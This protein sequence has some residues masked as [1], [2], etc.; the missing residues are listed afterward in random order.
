[1][2]QTGTILALLLGLTLSVL[3]IAS[4]APGAPLYNSSWGGPALQ[5]ELFA[6]LVNP[7]AL[8]RGSASGFGFILPLGD[9]HAPG[10]KDFGE[11]YQLLLNA[12]FGG[13]A[14]EHRDSSFTHL[15][16]GAL[17][18]GP[19]LSL[20]YSWSWEET[21]F[22]DGHYQAGLLLRPGEAI[23]LGVVYR[24]LPQDSL[25]EAGLGVRPL[26]FSD[27]WGTRLTLDGNIRWIPDEEDLDFSTASVTVEV[28]DG[29]RLSAGYDHQEEVFSLGARVNLR[30]SEAGLAATLEDPGDHIP[31]SVSYG[32]LR[33]TRRRTVLEQPRSEVIEYDRTGRVTSHP[34]VHRFSEPHLPLGTI[35]ADL[36]RFRDDPSVGAI[37][38]NGT[39]LQAPLA[40]VSELL[41][42]FN[43]VRLQGKR[44]FFYFDWADPVAYLLAAAVSDQIFFHP[45]AVLDLR[46]FSYSGL[47]LG[48]FL[49]NYGVDVHNYRSHDYKTAGDSLSEPS[50]TEA[51]REGWEVLLE[52]LADMYNEVLAVARE[53]HL[54]DE[55]DRI[56]AAGPYLTAKGALD[57]GLIDAILYPDQLQETIF[58][59]LP[60]AGR[61]RAPDRTRRATLAWGSDR[62]GLVQVI[63]GTG[64]IIPGEAIAGESIGGDSFSRAIR[65]ARENPFV[66]GIILR[67]ETGGGAITA[68]DQIAREVALTRD[69]G[70]PV[71]VSMGGVAASGGYY[72]SAP[73]SH[74]V[75]N[76]ATITGSIGVVAIQADMERLLERFAIGTDTVR[77][78]PRADFGSILRAP[79]PEEKD[80]WRAYIDD[81]YQRFL[82]VVAENRALSREEVH[83]VAQ[84]K[85]WTGRQALERGLVDS[86]GGLSRA[87]E[88]M[89]GL[90]DE[91]LPLRTVHTVPGG[92]RFDLN[93]ALGAGG[94]ARFA[95][96][97]RNVLAGS[98][99]AGPASVR[100]GPG[101]PLSQELSRALAE[102]HLLATLEG[103]PLYLMP[104]GVPGVTAPR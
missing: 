36:E 15:I 59:I 85:V 70:K 30:R 47:Y 46:G 5:D 94:W 7:A 22:T 97:P 72:I 71:V 61:W 4:A 8:A 2:K 69:A 77:T 38:V 3:P 37:L 54:P 44:V 95:G 27:R 102:L 43:E 45:T 63:H 39:Y 73:A 32:F 62:G 41:E 84:G 31:E 12:S 74:I 29:V 92:T 1:M 26:W 42:A 40:Y 50:M 52:D 67:I 75:A 64:P 13:Y 90:L 20:G 18:L 33:A 58:Q 100:L 16:S 51:E 65:E 56:V 25:L 10:Q 96:L 103:S 68:S 55:A 89:A 98:G 76:P 34:R 35:V 6:P 91:S 82:D 81:G 104:Y 19:S 9:D 14:L 57:A 88:I 87:E 23:S 24:D 99:L 11:R 83:Q 17:P 101:R 48:Q 86:L 79:S 66:Q 49:H 21:S 80:L 53:S 28:L 60:Q 93:R 78:A